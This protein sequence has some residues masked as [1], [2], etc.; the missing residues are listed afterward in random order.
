MK[1]SIYGDRNSSLNAYKALTIWLFCCCVW[2]FE[3]PWTAHQASLSFSISQRL[4]KL[5]SIEWMMPSNYLILCRSLILLPSIFPSIKVFSNESAVLIRW[6]KY[7]NF[8]FSISPSSEYSGLIS[9]RVDWFDLAGQGALRSLPRLGWGVG[10]RAGVCLSELR[11]RLVSPCSVPRPLS[12][13]LAPPA[14]C[15]LCL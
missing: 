1:Q 12:G 7:Q 4:L 15:P 2:L 14:V 13:A 11:P 8:S 5:M 6:P 3:T 10:N 9:F